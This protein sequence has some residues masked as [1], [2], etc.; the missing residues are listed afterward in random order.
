MQRR[1]VLRFLVVALVCAALGV[2]APG[3]SAKQPGS[4]DRISYH[5]WTRGADFAAGTFEGARP[6]AVGDGAI[7]F[8]T[9]AGARAY[10]DP[11]D[12]TAQTTAYDYD[13]W[14]S[15]A[16]S[17]GIRAHRARLELDGRHAGGHVDPGRDAGDD[18]GRHSDEVV[19]HGPLDVA[20]A[21]R[22]ER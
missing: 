13:R 11:F 9:S 22:D 5:G 12:S 17:A 6:V 4:H 18:D 15:P 19:R 10:D 2:V 1:I 7:T 3:G 14:T 8:G 20:D 16:Y 21:L